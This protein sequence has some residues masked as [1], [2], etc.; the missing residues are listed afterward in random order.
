ML[1]SLR[2][3]LAEVAASRARVVALLLGS[4]ESAASFFHEAAAQG[5][6]RHAQAE[7]LRESIARKVR[8]QDAAA[9]RRASGSATLTERAAELGGLLELATLP[10]RPGEAH[11]L[12]AELFDVSLACEG[13]QV[14]AHKVILSACS[15]FFRN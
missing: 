2:Q 7:K 4:A 11:P 13:G 15:P 12:E 1:A 5:L 3:L 10:L 6:D 9:S 8:A 14:S